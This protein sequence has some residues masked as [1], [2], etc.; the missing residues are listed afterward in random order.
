MDNLIKNSTGD[1][2]R[3]NE[4]ID[5]LLKSN[6]WNLSRNAR[7]A[8]PKIKRLGDLSAHSRRYLAKKSDIDSHRDDLRLALEELILLIDYPS[9]KT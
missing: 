2:F 7:L 4:L 3:L 1:F 5:Q 6:K 8:L 9:W